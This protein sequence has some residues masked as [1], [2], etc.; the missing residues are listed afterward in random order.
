MKKWKWLTLSSVAVGAL[1]LSAC[2]A[3]APGPSPSVSEAPPAPAGPTELKVALPVEPSM[4]TPSLGNN[5]ADY[6][7]LYPVYDRLIHF[8]PATMKMLPDAGLATEWGFTDDTNTVFRMKIRD[9]VKFHDGTDLDAAAV[10]TSLNFYRNA[11]E[12][13][14]AA[15]ED[16][17]LVTDIKAIGED[18]VE[19]TLSQPYTVLPAVLADRAGMITS[20]KALE[21]H[22][23]EDPGRFLAGTGPYMWTSWNKGENWTYERFDD[24]WGEPAGFD[25]IEFTMMPDA[26]ARVNAFRTG[27]ID[28][29]IDIN[30]LDVPSLESESTLRVENETTTA[31][32]VMQINAVL[33]PFDDARVRQAI[34]IGVDRDATVKTLFPMLPGGTDLLPTSVPAANTHWASAG[35]KVI[36]DPDGAKKLLADAGHAGGIDLPTCVVSSDQTSQDAFQLYQAQLANV[37]IRATVELQPTIGACNEEAK[38]G[39]YAAIVAGIGGFPDQFLATSRILAVNI[40]GSFP[41]LYAL[42][43]EI[44]LAA[45]QEAQTKVYQK[46]NAQWQ[47]DVPTVALYT[48]PYVVGY[49][50]ALKG[51]AAT[52]FGKPL[53]ANLSAN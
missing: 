11:R 39:K 43:D 30:P 29:I 51:T 37:G 3:P 31:I 45:G 42:V 21:E 13:E 14:P 41:E 6:T 4:A 12:V 27:Q 19:M 25:S 44:A 33:P 9:G 52:G 49:N 2:A 24:Y 1:A 22:R 7:S 47:K 26:Q 36:F 5:S 16:L 34:N 20:P 35:N 15:A 40:A 32:A 50:A 48:R 46:V 8:D 10:V 17:K 23:T 53:L 28:F 38:K 18:E